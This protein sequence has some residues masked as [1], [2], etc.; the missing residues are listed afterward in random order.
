MLK[1]P[2]YYAFKLVSNLARG[3]ALD[4]CVK[5]PLMDTRKYG[6]VPLLDVSASYEAEAG[7]GAVFMVNRS[8]AESLTT[9]IIW[10]DGKGFLVDKAWQ[11]AGS[12]PKETNSWES[13]NN[14]VAKSIPVP[15]V[16]GGRTTLPLPPL[17]FTVLTIRAF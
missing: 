5:A 3:E 11:L 4:A 16:D 9:S 7:Q 13:P 15:T 2:S 8:Q 17:S 6:P 10:Q 14:L 12:D 1:Q